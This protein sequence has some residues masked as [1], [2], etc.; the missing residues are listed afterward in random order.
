MTGKVIKVLLQAEAIRLTRG[1]IE[2]EGN[3]YN[4][5]SDAAKRRSLQ[6]G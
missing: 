1:A 3:N 4:M 5:D 2:L 6:F